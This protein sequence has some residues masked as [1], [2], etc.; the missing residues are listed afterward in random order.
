MYMCI[1][2]CIYIHIL[3]FPAGFNIRKHLVRA[4]VY[5]LT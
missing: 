4:K 3:S 2:M 5:P 1:Y